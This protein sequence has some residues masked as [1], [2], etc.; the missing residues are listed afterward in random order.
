M[1][2]NKTLQAIFWIVDLGFVTYWLI[3][4]SELIPA[5]Y[6]YND[7]SNPLLVDWNWSFFPLDIAISITGFTSLRLMNRQK[8]IWY[9]WAL[10]SLTLMFCSGLQALSFWVLRGDFDWIWW[11]PNLF[12]MVYPLVVIPQLLKKNAVK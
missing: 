3:T 4:F 9:S 11:L 5:E 7:Y 12:L 8:S 6:L 2:K 10:V 1:K